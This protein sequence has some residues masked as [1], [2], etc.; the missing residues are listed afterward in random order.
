MQSKLIVLNS[1][2]AGNG[3]ILDCNGK[4]LVL[5]CGVVFNKCA[6]NL[7]Y[8]ISNVQSVLV[9]HNHSDHA[10]Y[11]KQYIAHGLNV[12][13]PSNF[14]NCKELSPLKRYNFGDFKVIPLLVPHGETKCYAYVIDTP[15]KQR[16]LFA[17][18][19]SEFPYIIK[20]LDHIFIECNYSE[21]MRLNMLLDGIEVR[22]NS[23]THLSL[24]RCINAIVSLYSQNLKSITLLHLSPKI[25]DSAAFKKAIE[26][27]FKV[28]TN[29]AKENSVFVLR[30]DDF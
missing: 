1:G 23:E 20:G 7:H 2:S 13:A 9:T 26:D 5:E 30:N 4:Q 3:Y 15:D 25:S 8:D 27:K 11:I 14:K 17:T 19:L 21:E 22:S 16:C 28:D 29:I 24:D 10:K 18:D 6:K 12:Y